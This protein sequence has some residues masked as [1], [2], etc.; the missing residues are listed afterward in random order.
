MYFSVPMDKNNL[1]V[2]L[3]PKYIE[4]KQTVTAEELCNMRIAM[5]EIEFNQTL[6]YN[7]RF[8]PIL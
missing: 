4:F 1:T 8:Q 7:A 2:P 6:R 3:P 5:L